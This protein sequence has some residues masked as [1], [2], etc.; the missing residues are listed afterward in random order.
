MLALADTLDGKPA[1]TRFNIS[2]DEWARWIKS[3]RAVEDDMADILQ[4]GRRKS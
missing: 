4:Q 2:S 3:Y 1:R